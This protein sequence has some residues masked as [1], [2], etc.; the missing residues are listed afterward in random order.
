MSLEEATTS[1]RESILGSGNS[2]FEPVL[3]RSVKSMHILHLPLA[4]FTM[5]VLANHIGY[6]T[7]LMTLALRSVFTSFRALPALTSDILR[8]LY[9]LD[10]MDGTRLLEWL[11]TS[12]FTPHRSLAEQS[13]TSMSSNKSLIKMCSRSSDGFFPR[14]TFC[15]TLSSH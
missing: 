3:L 4:F 1:T 9:S 13:T 14:S 2:T 6:F 11:R 5:T 7:S 10:L 15:S 12:L 8:S